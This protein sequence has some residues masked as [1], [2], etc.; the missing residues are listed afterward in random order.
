[1]NAA[2]RRLGP[3]LVAGVVAWFGLAWLA[4]SQ[5]Q[6]TPP[7]AGFDLALLLE[8]ARRVTHGLS[9]YDPAMLAGASPDATSL[10]YSY[11]P[12]VAQAM[13]LVAW[14]PDRVVWLG[15]VLG[16]T[17]GLGLVAAMI[18]RGYGA[19]GLSVAVRVVAVSP[20]VLPFAIALLFGNLDAW[21]PLLYGALLLAVLPGASNRVRV[22]G[23]AAAAAVTIAKLHPAPLLL[24]LVAIVVRE[25]HGPTWRVLL[26]AAV[27]GATILAISLLVWGVGPWLDYVQV[28]RVG[29]S[30][31]LVDLRNLGPVSLIGQVSGLSGQALAA[32]QLAIL[33]VVLLVSVLAAWRIP[34]RLT[35][36]TVVSAASLAT[37]PVTWYHYP[38][39]MLP[40]AIAL[41][42]RSP[43]TRTWLVAALLLVDLAIAIPVLAWLAVLVV[44][45]A[46]LLAPTR[47]TTIAILSGPS[48]S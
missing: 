38:V 33:V 1:M 45:L 12:P 48:G 21:Y 20:L 22:A 42:I 18:A 29:S 7:K 19:N 17:A 6:G 47:S 14:L 16:A 15:W 36:F 24:W 8:A 25:R 23:G 13:T 35:S 28:V 2:S 3:W 4:W 37:L 39:A 31:Q 27:T 9:P 32:L 43:S 34:D 10:F 11:P 26:A 5:W 40:V 46:A 44:V 30:A 41:A